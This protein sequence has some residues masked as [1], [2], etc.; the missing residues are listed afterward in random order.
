MV[1]VLYF[2]ENIFSQQG[3]GR[4][5]RR[6]RQSARSPASTSFR[7]R[8]LVTRPLG[9]ARILIIWSCL[10]SPSSTRTTPTGRS[11]SD[12]RSTTVIGYEL[13]SRIRCV[14]EVS[15]DPAGGGRSLAI[16]RSIRPKDVPPV[17]RV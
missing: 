9:V 14:Y 10:R 13:R 1:I 8:S 6:P 11:T 15:R 4:R 5:Y 16:T 17:G 7:R 3:H 2:R 12:A